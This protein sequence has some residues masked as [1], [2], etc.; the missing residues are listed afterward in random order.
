MS[1]LAMLEK[2]EGYLRKDKWY[3]MCCPFHN[4]S[5]PSMDVD[6]TKPGFRCWACGKTG[7]YVDLIS[8]LERIS[9]VSAQLIVAKYRPKGGIGLKGI[10]GQRKKEIIY[11]DKVEVLDKFAPVGKNT[12]C[13]KYL[14]SRKIDLRLAKK[15][16]VREGNSLEYGWRDRI[17]FPIFD[18]DGNL[19]SIEGRDITGK[20]Y[21]RYK[22]WTGSEAGLGIFGIE[23]VLKK[24]YGQGMIFV[25]GAI[26]VLSVWLCGF[27]GLG[28]SC[29]DMTSIQMSQIQR[30]T[31]YPITILDG[32]KPGTERE[33]E[34]VLDRLNERYSKKFK[35]YKIIEI[36]YEDT[37][38]NDLHRKGKLKIFLRRVVV[39]E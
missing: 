22:K 25:E 38:P 10:L 35:K 19:C 37:D 5:R 6:I 31:N 2:Y 17:I 21:L 12:E 18:I 34:E 39:N 4:D 23:Q 16:S 33:R 11:L 20:S 32:V 27:I 24:Y 7:N 13:E 1:Y 30:I 26:D 8:K 15:F 14:K 29:S 9:K 28:M 3:R 36:P